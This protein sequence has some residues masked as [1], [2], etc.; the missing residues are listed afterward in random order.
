[1]NVILV[2]SKNQKRMAEVD[3]V[4]FEANSVVNILVLPH[5][6]AELAAS[7]FRAIQVTLNQCFPTAGPRP[8]TGPW[9]Q[10]Y[11]AARGKYFIVEIF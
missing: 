6:T 9:H 11:R 10:L 2:I 8:G 7:M 4:C 5:D 1:M 3:V